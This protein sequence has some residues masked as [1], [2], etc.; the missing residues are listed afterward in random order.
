MTKIDAG[1]YLRLIEKIRKECAMYEKDAIYDPVDGEICLVKIDGFGFL[2]AQSLG[3]NDGHS[4]LMYT[5]DYGVSL[6]V[7]NENIRVTS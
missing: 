1:L 4:R 2:R 3:R 6:P 5:V 7:Q